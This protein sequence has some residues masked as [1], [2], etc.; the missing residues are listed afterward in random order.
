VSSAGRSIG[1]VGDG[2]SVSGAGGAVRSVGDG[3]RDN[4]S[5][6]GSETFSMPNGTADSSN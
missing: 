5:F 6:T 1:S 2:R 4:R 3:F